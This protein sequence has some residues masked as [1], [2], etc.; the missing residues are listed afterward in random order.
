[1]NTRDSL[2]AG[3]RGITMVETLVALVVLS[4]GMLGIAALYVETMRANRTAMIRGH[5]IN[6]VQDMADRIRANARA[7]IAYDIG[8]YGGNP[9]THN[10][11]AGGV[12]TDL[13]LAE[14]DLAWWKQSAQATLP[15]SV[16]NTQFFPGAAATVPDRFLV[17]I[18][19]TEP[20]SD[21]NNP[22]NYSYQ[23]NLELLPVTP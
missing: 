11:V 16:V 8:Q 13:D 15:G 20:G 21:P 10:C 4:I 22:D 18:T 7:Q 3:Q 5:A 6:L 9:V 14:D 17:S 23:T 2:A 19:W 1:M 12:C